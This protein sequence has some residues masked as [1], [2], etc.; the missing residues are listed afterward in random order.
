MNKLFKKAISLTMAAAIVVLVGMG[1][2]AVTGGSGITA[3]AVSWLDVSNVVV[4]DFTTS[5]ITVSWQG[6]ANAD[7]Y[8]VAYQETYG[9]TSEYKVA[10]Q[11]TGT[12]YTISGLKSGEVYSIRVTPRNAAGTEALAGTCYDA[13][14]KVSTMKGVKQDTWFHW[15]L[16]AE[17][18]WDRQYGADGYEYKWKNPSGKVTKKGKVNYTSL[19]F[20]V[21]NNNVYQFMVR[22]Y[23][24]IDGKTYYSS[25]KTIQVFEQPWIKSVAVKTNKKSKKCLKI[26]WYKQKGAT[27]YD[28]YVSQ[29]KDAKNYKKVKS[30][31][32]NKTSI[33]ITKFNKKNIKGTYYVYV[34]SKVKTSS[35]TS[36]S[37]ISY[38]WQTGQ[39]IKGYVR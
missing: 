23:Q 32:K 11:T 31:G 5:T 18:S 4:T 26:S 22:A 28:V 15:S 17:V 21:K 3:Q 25:W 2:G 30:V 1:T 38:I 10:G 8:E 9:S 37:G 13:R 19:Y 35:G 12:A 36:K 20:S 24:T 7:S 33:S 29:K 16:S 14:T 39:N 27:G 6:D 34:V